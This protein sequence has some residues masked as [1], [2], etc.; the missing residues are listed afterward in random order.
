MT[1]QKRR[2]ED[3]QTLKKVGVLL[4]VGIIFFAM[5][6]IIA[7]LGPAI[8]Y[9]YADHTDY[10]SLESP[11]KVEKEE[12]QACEDVQVRT[13]RF[14]LLDTR[15]ISVKD[16]VA[17]KQIDG[18]DLEV[19]TVERPEFIHKSEEEEIIFVYKL[20]CKERDGISLPPGEYKWRGIIEV[21]VKG[22]DK[23]IPFYTET[24]RVVE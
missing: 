17:V 11:M 24:F 3:R 18:V 10:F 16:L 2:E 14:S 8:Y 21:K 22:V 20:P 23:P 7:L 9:R 15:A 19:T 4:F 13:K 12:Y 1:N 5:L 6:S